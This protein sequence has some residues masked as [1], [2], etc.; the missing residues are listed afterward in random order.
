VCGLRVFQKLA[1]WLRINC[2]FA[3][4]KTTMNDIAAE[5]AKL[6]FLKGA[7]YS[8]QVER[9]ARMDNYFEY[10]NDAIEVLV[11][12]GGK[13]ISVSREMSQS[14]SFY[15]LFMKKYSK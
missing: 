9:I 1:A 3:P 15:S 14:R 4:K 6:H 5:L 13:S 7:D 11:Y 8:R 12:K 2:I 10:N